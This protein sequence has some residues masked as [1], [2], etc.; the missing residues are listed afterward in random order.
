MIVYEIRLFLIDYYNVILPIHIFTDKVKRIFICATLV[1]TRWCYN[2]LI[3]IFLITVLT[4][5]T[6][7][8][9]FLAPYEVFFILII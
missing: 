8:D 5:T 4:T 1:V 7:A 9:S 2:R 6:P 3:L